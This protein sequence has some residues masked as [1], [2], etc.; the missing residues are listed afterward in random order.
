MAR[1]ETFSAE[2]G[3][4]VACVHCGKPCER[5]DEY[6][7]DIAGREVLFYADRCPNC[8]NEYVNAPEILKTDKELLGAFQPDASDLGTYRRVLNLSSRDREFRRHPGYKVAGTLL[9]Y[10]LEEDMADVVLLAHQG[11]TEE[12]VMAFTKRDLYDA[13]Q[14]RMG[15]GRAVV[16]GYNFRANLM[17][18]AQLQRFAE[19]DRGLHP[20]IAVM[21]RPC[22]V[23]TLR[24]LHWDR[25]VPGYEMVFGLGTFCY[26]NYAPGAWGGE[27]LRTL[28]GFDP[29]DIRHI[30]YVGEELVFTPSQGE[31]KRVAQ[32]D[33][34]GLVNANCLQCYDFTAKFSDISVGSLGGD[35]PFEAV[36]L[37]TEG[38]EMVVGQAVHDGFLATSGQLY[39][40]VDVAE[41]EQ[42]TL[43]YLNAM[44]GIKR[45]LTGRL[46]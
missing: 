23:Y 45:E 20:R 14:L 35:E 4:V 12:P 29:L 36:L 16:T 8:R 42:R 7:L 26:G 30:R 44:V 3:A 24:K 15:L 31:A 43:A 9:W 1:G 13:W 6:A 21:G 2:T 25:F 34:A 28:L 19:V 32:E 11:V 39:G 17:T 27:K 40:K 22:Q 5:I 41:E 33:V 37:R 38:G 10:L 18:L 46:R